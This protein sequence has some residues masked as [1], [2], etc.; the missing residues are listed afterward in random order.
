MIQKTKTI[1]VVMCTYNGAKYLKE[2]L[3]SIINQTYPIFELIIQDDCSTDTTMILLD[4]YKKGYPFIQ[5]HNNEKRKGINGN[6][7]SAIEKATGDYIAISD[8][9]DIWELD[10]L[11]KQMDAI[12]DKLLCFCFSVPFSDTV[13][14]GADLRIPNFEIERML[15]ISAIAGHTMLLSRQLLPLIPAKQKLS[16]EFVYDFIIQIV[17]AAYESISFCSST[18]VNHRRFLGAATYTPIQNYSKSLSNILSNIKRTFSLYKELRPAIK[19]RLFNITE[20]LSS[21]S[22]ESKSKNS[23]LKLAKY[24]M[25][26]SIQDFIL[27]EFYCVKY[28]DHLFYTK[29]KNQFLAVLRAFYFPISCSDYFRWMSKSCKK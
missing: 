15:Y 27:M 11:E 25:S 9:D 8:Q 18:K 17:A 19:Q 22:I 5:I 13:K 2:Q 14:V 26:N 20:L 21:L 23:A 28:R 29:E 16:Q 12:A 24:Q 10:K 7:F 6:F 3:D 4:E 1:S